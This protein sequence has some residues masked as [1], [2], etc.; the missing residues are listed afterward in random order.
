MFQRLRQDGNFYKIEKKVSFRNAMP[1]SEEFIRK[2]FIHA[3]RM[4]FTKEGHHRLHRSGGLIKRTPQ[5]VFLNAFQ[6]KLGEF[7]FYNYFT[8]IVEGFQCTEPDISVTP[9]GVWD[10]GDFTVINSKGLI[11]KVAIKT[12]K[13]FGNLLLLE[14]KDW[15]C[16]GVYVPSI[17]T[18]KIYKPDILTLVRIKPYL[19]VWQ[20]NSIIKDWNISREDYEK[21]F[22]RVSQEN[23]EYDIPGCITSRDLREIIQNRYILP[24]KGVIGKNTVMDAE[25]YYVQAGD[26]KCLPK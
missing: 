17:Q 25:N 6:G 3:Y 5:E 4:A 22:I 26:M 16:D 12:T 23:W 9:E 13:F 19:R 8:R 24:Q 20:V 14:T 2:A 10:N 11:L 7:G 15:N 21:L 1:L 18:E